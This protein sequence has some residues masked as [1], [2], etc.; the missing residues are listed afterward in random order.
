MNTINFFYN[1]I[2]ITRSVEQW[3]NIFQWWIPVIFQNIHQCKIN[4]FI[5]IKYVVSC[6]NWI[7]GCCIIYSQRDGKSSK[8]MLILESLTWKVGK[9]LNRPLTYWIV[10]NVEN[11]TLYV[12]G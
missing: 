9:D 8:F 11:C 6:D 2:C 7:G 12:G 4:F 10:E 3:N 1:N 5:P